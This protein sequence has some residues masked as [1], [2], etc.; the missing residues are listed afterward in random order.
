MN[1]KQIVSISNGNIPLM[2]QG[3]GKVGVGVASPHTLLQVAGPVAT[4]IATKTTGYPITGSRIRGQ[5][6]RSFRIAL[7]TRV[8]RST[9][10][11]QASALPMNSGVGPGIAPGPQ[12]QTGRARFPSIRLS[13]VSQSAGTGFPLVALQTQGLKIQQEGRLFVAGEAMNGFDVVR[14][15]GLRLHASS[16]LTASM[17][18]AKQR[19]GLEVHTPLSLPLE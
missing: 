1:G 19:R 3:T 18:V 9:V 10:R 5:T 17:P 7:L 13:R 16:A 14:F 2:P 8:I 12:P 11:A 15:R 6:C 4:P